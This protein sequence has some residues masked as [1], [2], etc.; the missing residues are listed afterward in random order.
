MRAPSS[1]WLWS[2]EERLTMVESTGIDFVLIL[3][4]ASKLFGISTPSS[5]SNNSFYDV[6]INLDRSFVIIPIDSIIIWGLSELAEFRY[7]FIK[8]LGLWRFF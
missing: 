3:S 2:I 5:Y 6:Y 7:S 1:D 8:T 4:E